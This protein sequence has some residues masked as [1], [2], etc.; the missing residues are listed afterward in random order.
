M[1]D[2][3]TMI[4]NNKSYQHKM[5]KIAL[6]IAILLGMTLFATAQNGGGLF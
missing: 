3:T 2:T 4:T 6:T 1:M 5:K